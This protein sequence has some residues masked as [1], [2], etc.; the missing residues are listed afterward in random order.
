MP[1]GPRLIC[2]EFLFKLI[3]SV[4]VLSSLAVIKVLDSIGSLAGGLA[5][6]ILSISFNLNSLGT[7]HSSQHKI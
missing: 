3:F 5:Y 1:P 2:I 6:K 7:A 4:S